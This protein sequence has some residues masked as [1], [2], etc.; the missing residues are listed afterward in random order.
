M[1]LSLLALLLG[2]GAPDPDALLRRHDLDGASAA[3][4]RLHGEPL[5]VDHRAVDA[6]ATRAARDPGITT[7][8]VAEAM[9]AVR[10]V[11]AVPEAGLADVDAPFSSMEALLRGVERG[12]RGPLLVAVARPETRADGDPY[13]QDA[14][15]PC[16]GGRVIGWAQ[17]D[18]AALGARIDADPPGRKVVVAVR[19]AEGDF[20]MVVR[21]DLEGW[22]LVGATNR[23][24][25]SRVLSASAAGATAPPVVEPQAAP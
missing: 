1:V 20:W 6:L 3:W 23:E 18:L 19:G 25:A 9:R 13:V 15:L 14:P 4:E 24:G 10:L 11:E 7:A 5:D 8:Y 12:V 21:R 22:W 16:R 2:C 17:T